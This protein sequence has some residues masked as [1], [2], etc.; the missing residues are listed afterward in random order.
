VAAIPDQIVAE[1][2]ELP[3]RS[4]SPFGLAPLMFR[5]VQ[6]GRA[7]RQERERQQSAGH[8]SGV[9]PAESADETA[10]GRHHVRNNGSVRHFS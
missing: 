5:V 3:S 4:G 1:E 2:T 6:K 10:L 7:R 9:A 8:R